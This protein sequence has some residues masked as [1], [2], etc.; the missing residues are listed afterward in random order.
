[1]MPPP[2]AFPIAAL[3]DARVALRRSSTAS[4]FADAFFDLR[5]VAMVPPRREDISGALACHS[6]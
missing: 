5:F 2:G 3:T 6:P 1:M 4:F